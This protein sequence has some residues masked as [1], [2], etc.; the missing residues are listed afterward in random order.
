MKKI[1]FVIVL[2]YG[3]INHAQQL[4]EVIPPSPETA[5]L[6]QY[7]EYP[8]DYST[9]LPQISIPLCE[10]RSGELTV[11]I[12]M[13]YH[14]SGFKLSDR[15][16]P[17]ARGWSLNTGGAV[18][19]TI[20]GSTDFGDN[21]SGNFPFPHPFPTTNIFPNSAL[22]KLAYAERIMHYSGNPSLVTIADFLDAEY[23]I[24][25]YSMG[26]KNGKLIFEDINGTK[27][28][29]FIP[30][31]PYQVTPL[32]SNGSLTGIDILDDEGVTYK[33]FPSERSD[34]G[35][36]AYAISHIISADKTDTIRY[37]YVGDI[38]KRIS[39][40]QFI[41]L[42]DKYYPEPPNNGPS[43]KE[44]IITNT[45]SSSYQTSRVSQIDFDNGKIVFNLIDGVNDG[46]EKRIDNIQVLDLNDSIIKT[47]KFHRSRLHIW[48]FEAYETSTLDSLTIHDR[49]DFRIEK[50]AFDHYE[51]PPI[52]APSTATSP[53]FRYIDWWGYYNASGETDMVPR[54]TNIDVFPAN[55]GSYDL[56]NINADREPKLNA[57]LSG[58]IKS[59][60]YPT[61]GK[62][63]LTYGHNK[64]LSTQSG[65]VKN[66]PGL[67][68]EQIAHMNQLGDT[69]T[70][71]FRYGENEVGHGF[72]E[73]EPI[74]S[75][76]VNENVHID[77]DNDNPFE[78][79]TG[80]RERIY[81]SG[82]VPELS[83]LATRPVRYPV[84]TEYIGT[85]N[86]N[87]GK[88]VYEYDR[89]PWGPRPIGPGKWDIPDYN[90]WNETVLKKKTDF[91]VRENGNLKTYDIRRET[92]NTYTPSE[93]FDIKGL[94][95]Q[96]RITATGD[97]S[98]TTGNYPESRI[99][100][101][102]PMAGNFGSRDIYFFGEYTIPVGTK[103]LT[104]TVEKVY[105]DDGST[106]E[107]KTMYEYNANQLMSRIRQERSNEQT[108]LTLNTLIK[109]PFD[110]TG[111]GVLEQMSDPTVNMLNFRIEESQEKEGKE[112]KSTKTNYNDWGST[113]PMI[114]PQS[115]EVKKDPTGYE[116]LIEFADYDSDGNLSEVSKTDGTPIYYIWGYQGQYPIAKIE[117]FSA[118]QANAVQ[119]LIDLAINASNIDTDNCRQVDCKEEQLRQ[120]LSDLRAAPQLASS[121]VTSYTYDPL[122]GITSSTDPRGYTIYYGYDAFQRLKEVKDANGHLV[123]DYE[124]HYPG[125]QP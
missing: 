63:E 69:I 100:T 35:S 104:S 106:I 124:Y 32:V 99:A 62:T 59:V 123:K 24:F 70:K 40:E 7:Q 54:H 28:P 101:G 118:A 53:N 50:Y 91:E 17:I 108:E 110:F 37:S 42:E 9:G 14:A 61:G 60:H 65:Q 31:K 74:L 88:T 30:L 36:T 3:A 80:Y 4:P 5:A 48:P 81:Y 90:Y 58:V 95:V 112:I 47:I 105:H 122:V 2:I 25:S 82:F 86:K 79:N 34:A 38:Q 13:S 11:P 76:M 121:M 51:T 109:Y 49:N 26:G 6:F 10:I 39:M 8:M 98:S 45:N 85:P 75:Y 120:A 22:N 89:I 92:I 56:G 119:S 114:K 33:F 64:Y 19:R 68:V 18:S 115:I 107:N 73:L 77:F 72:I 21:V 43:Y 125:Q 23:D 96:R 55:G 97:P 83:E 78:Y 102:E 20:H 116:P 103:H 66:G 57:L 27:T 71:T 52:S 84:V 111:I 117:N 44:E 1:L 67:R 16:G 113:N 12:S 87:N 41:R 93:D 15:D 46:D 94:H 29:R